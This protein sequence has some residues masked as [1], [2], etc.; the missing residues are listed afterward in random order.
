[1][2]FHCVMWLEIGI[3]VGW[4]EE[5]ACIV[6]LPSPC[7]SNSVFAVRTGNRLMATLRGTQTFFAGFS[8][9]VTM[10]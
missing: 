5:W 9:F 8:I 6:H 2:G 4:V 7:S 10:L 3:T 1:M